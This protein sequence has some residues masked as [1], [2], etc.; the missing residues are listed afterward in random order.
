MSNCPETPP[1]RSKSW[2]RW[3][4]QSGRRFLIYYLLIVLFMSIMQRQ[5]LYVP[6]QT[7][8]MPVRAS[9]CLPGGGEDI[10]LQ[11]ADGLQLHGWHLLPSKLSAGNA[12]DFDR[13]LAEGRQVVIFFH[14][15][16]GNRLHRDLDY[17][18]FSRLNL[19]IIA[20]DYRGYGENPG[21][22]T[23]E[24]FAADAHA[25]WKYVTET[26][27]VSPD[28]IIL[29]GESLGGGVATR[30][31]AEVCAAGT[32]PAGL[33]LRSTFSSMVAAA[34]YHHPWLPVSWI[35]K[36]QYRSDQR[37]PQLTAP[38]LMLH[39]TNDTIVPLSLGQQLFHLAPDRAANGIPKTFVELKNS[40]HNDVLYADPDHF[41]EAIKKFLA[42]LP[43]A[44]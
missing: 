21:S 6:S 29:Y 37:I 17:Q 34:G 31:A 35:L 9:G 39:G 10:S 25:M 3:C 16:G 40:G 18:L 14:G 20:F 15:N 26:R 42:T 28:R 5:L 36:D 24:N 44:K 32:P 8:E 27:H 23:E 11:T 22:P 41:K 43:Q 12:D 4:L 33:I 30:L 7:T 1:D 13:F 19:H 38:L 2:Y